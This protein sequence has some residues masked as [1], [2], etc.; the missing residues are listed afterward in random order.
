MDSESLKG[1][2]GRWRDRNRSTVRTAIFLLV[3]VV[4][5]ISVLT[6]FSSPP[7]VAPE[8]DGAPAPS[9][10]SVLAG[11]PGPIVERVE[12]SESFA[13]LRFVDVET[14]KSVPAGTVSYRW[15]LTGEQ[16]ARSKTAF[17][18]GAIRLSVPPRAKKLWLDAS[19]EGMATT[20]VMCEVDPEG[21][22]DLEVPLH[23]L[24][25]LRVE[26]VESK[27]GSPVSGASIRIVR[28]EATVATGVGVM[29]AEVEC[30]TAADGVTTEAVA[31]GNYVVSC[32]G[33][34]IEP[35]SQ[36]WTVQSGAQNHVRFQVERWTPVLRGIVVEAWSSRPIEG[37]MVQVGDRTQSTGADGR[38]HVPLGMRHFSASRSGGLLVKPPDSRPD[39]HEEAVS[40]LWH[41]EELTVA[42]GRRA[43]QLQIV[44]GAGRSHDGWDAE[45]HASQ[46]PTNQPDWRRLERCGPGRFVLPESVEKNRGCTLRLS[47]QGAG[48]RYVSSWQLSIRDEESCRVFVWRVPDVDLRMVRVVSR[49]DGSPVA[50]AT[51]EALS[52]VV[53]DLGAARKAVATV[54]YDA[55][56]AFPFSNNQAQLLGAATSDPSGKATLSL[57]VHGACFLRVGHPEFTTETVKLEDSS[58]PVVV[59]LK[60]RL[61]GCLR[62][63][64]IGR[65]K[66]TLTFVPLGSANMVDDPSSVV[67][68]RLK[69]GSF[70]I[71]D[72]ALGTYTAYLV[73]GGWKGALALFD[74]TMLGQID[75]VQ[76]PG[77]HVTLRVPE[78]SSTKVEVSSEDLRA[79]DELLFRH[80]NGHILIMVQAS[81][82]GHAEARLPPGLYTIARVRPYRYRSIVTEA[83]STLQIQLGDSIVKVAPE[84][85]QQAGRVRLMDGQE[86]VR[87]VEF[88]VEG[89]SVHGWSLWVTD[90]DG[91]IDFVSVPGRS[92]VL[93]PSPDLQ[94]EP[95]P[96][97]GK[98]WR[99]EGPCVGQSVTAT[100]L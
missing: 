92:F 6:R 87:G 65:S 59:R 81:P 80:S 82:R 71:E 64:L 56:T 79:G 68:V 3:V 50:G 100:E 53:G 78:V 33:D 8:A 88:G 19:A 77:K 97:H 91:W 37:A 36:P 96:Y 54:D 15:V 84:F 12:G 85:R 73:D 83:V 55:A 45:W 86:P 22:V 7:A 26:V 60:S 40:F 35:T 99:V 21:A 89:F 67:S 38:F 51:V 2:E 94:N 16:T 20:T 44:D 32:E 5:A 98:V 63:N 30:A 76:M 13:H 1:L 39:L 48:F 61:T 62:G 72:C 46:I 24:A 9:Q 4:A 47:Q 69:D 75:A 18:G 41:T 43:L 57:S 27:D 52:L 93:K 28:K 14:A 25:P 17:A 23:R 95:G 66:G 90:D 10:L 29:Q 74:Y 34:G 42:L 31:V 49:R 58:A 11:G 70:L